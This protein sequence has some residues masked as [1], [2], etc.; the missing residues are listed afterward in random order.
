MHLGYP[1]PL[2]H[3]IIMEAIMGTITTASASMVP[4]ER[5]ADKR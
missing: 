5:R 4:A 1:H 3:E 2:R